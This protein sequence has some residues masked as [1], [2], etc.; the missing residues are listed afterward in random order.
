MQNVLDYDPLHAGIQGWITSDLGMFVDNSI[1]Q[2]TGLYLIGN[3][4]L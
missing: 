1:N 2:L 4:H 3:R